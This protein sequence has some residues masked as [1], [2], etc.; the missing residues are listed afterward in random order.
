MT[1]LGAAAG[2]AGAPA[3]PRVSAVAPI[4]AVID[5]TLQGSERTS[6]FAGFTD[7][8]LASVSV[9]VMLIGG[10]EDTGVPVENNALAFDAMSEAP[11]VYRADIIGANHTHFSN[12]CAIGDLL[13]ENG[14]PQ[15]MWAAIG[16]GDLIGPYN[17]TCGPD[18]FSIAEA[19]RLQNLFVVAFFRRHLLGETDYEHYLSPEYADTEPAITYW[20][21]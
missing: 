1:S 3:D 15:E 5:S 9:P 6:P 16:A 18:V 13:I 8:Q 19:T 2:W 7:A 20:E 17:A 4:S 12:V 10:T 14:V 21:K 11:Q